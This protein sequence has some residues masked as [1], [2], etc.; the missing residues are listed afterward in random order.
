[1]DRDGIDHVP[2]P[3]SARERTADRMDDAMVSSDWIN[4]YLLKKRA[5]TVRNRANLEGL[6]WYSVHTDGTPRK[7]AT[8][9]RDS[10]YILMC[11]TTI[12]YQKHSVI[13]SIL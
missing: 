8:T 1:M 3:R 11:E 9:N 13:G 10:I 2:M 5:E 12:L 4:Y 6:P 7:R